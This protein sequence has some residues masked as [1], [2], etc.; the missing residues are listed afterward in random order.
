MTPFKRRVASAVAWSLA[1]SWSREIINLGTFLLLSRLLGP[2]AYGIAGMAMVLSA[3]SYAVLIEGFNGFIVQRK[4]LQPEHVDALFWLSM[5]LGV[6]MAILMIAGAPLVSLFF[7]HPD[8]TDVV[9]ALAILPILY[10]LSAVPLELLKRDFAFRVLGVRG[11]LASLFGG[12]AGV[13]LALTGHGVWSLVAMQIVLWTVQVIVLWVMN[14]WRP[15]FRFSLKHLRDVRYF[16]VNALATRGLI[17]LDLQLPRIVVG[18]FFGPVAL[19]YF[20]M[21]WRL[22]EILTML[23][24][25]PFSQVATSTFSHLQGDRSRLG[26]ASVTM[27]QVTTLL[28]FPSFVG[29]AAVAPELVATFFGP[30][31]EGAIP[32]VQCLPLVGIAWSINYCLY[33]LLRG[34]GV[35]GWRTATAVIELAASAVILPI[36]VPY[37]LEMIVVGI[38]LRSLLTLPVVMQVTR[39]KLDLAMAPLLRA[40]IPAVAGTIGMVALIAGWHS[41][42]QPRL[43]M[44]L[45]FGSSVAVGVA[46]FVAVTCLVAPSMLTTMLRFAAQFR[47]GR[48]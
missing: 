19:G 14:D 47:S 44:H 37:G 26:A 32:L 30:K 40:M 24:I 46:A 7:D 33:A 9:R 39:R 36:C 6:A 22:V 5:A 11:T 17:T 3:I 25:M 42:M 31:W 16:A 48:A 41:L 38:V 21:A 15:S 18:Y 35:M 8:V 23:I 27:I 1:G 20:T 29:I 12:A 28:A 43:T 2:E 10:A 34:T 4:D 45:L 13:T